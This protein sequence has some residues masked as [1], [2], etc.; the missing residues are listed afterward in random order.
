MTGKT[1][2]SIARQAN[3]RTL[4]VRETKKR[5]VDVEKSGGGMGGGRREASLEPVETIDRTKL[6]LDGIQ[7]IPSTYIFTFFFSPL[8]FT[9]QTVPFLYGFY[10]S[11]FFSLFFLFLFFLFLSIESPDCERPYSLRMK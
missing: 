6:E 5:K 10:F 2:D 11:F 4:E 7:C 3:K 8:F 1:I 9:L